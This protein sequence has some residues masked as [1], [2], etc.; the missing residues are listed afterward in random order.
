MENKPDLPQSA[1][2]TISSLSPVFLFSFSS[3]RQKSQYLLPCFPRRGVG[4]IGRENCDWIDV[5][6]DEEGAGGFLLAVVVTRLVFTF[7][8]INHLSILKQNCLDFN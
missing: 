7:T 4:A 3:P 2:D 8:K 5:I 6:D 1:Q